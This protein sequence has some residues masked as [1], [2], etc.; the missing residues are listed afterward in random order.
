MQGLWF[1]GCRRCVRRIEQHL[2]PL[3][4]FVPDLQL[5]GK[6]LGTV[7]QLRWVNGRY[8]GELCQLN[9]TKDVSTHEGLGKETGMVRGLSREQNDGTLHSSEL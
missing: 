1:K 4:I 2:A 7:F 5:P 8:L 6:C 3:V 9:G